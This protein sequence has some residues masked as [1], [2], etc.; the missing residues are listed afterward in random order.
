MAKNL[1]VI[2]RNICDD[3]ALA[4]LTTCLEKLLEYMQIATHALRQPLVKKYQNKNER[5]K[6]VWLY[7]LLPK[8]CS[9]NI[10]Y[11]YIE[12]T[13]TSF[14]SVLLMN[15]LREESLA[16]LSDQQIFDNLETSVI[17]RWSSANPTAVADFAE[18][19]KRQ[20]RSLLQVHPQLVAL[21]YSHTSGLYR[22]RTSLT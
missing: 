2:W 19:I 6:C 11:V 16:L 9:T 12:A 17:T 5:K 22:R 1:L 14:D 15:E 7:K 3:P 20:G 10:S 4:S 8:I 18:A 13:A 21:C